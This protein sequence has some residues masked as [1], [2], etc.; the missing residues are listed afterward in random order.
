MQP[1][2]LPIEQVLDE[3]REALEFRM[4]AVLAAPPGAGKTTRVPLALLNA[5][6]ASGKRIL[7]LEP[8]RIAT[9]SAARY[10][11]ASLGEQAGQTVGYRMRHDSR[12]SGATRI[13]VITEGILTRML[14]DDPAL[15][16]VGIVIFDEFHERSL[17]ADLGL[18]LCLQAQSLLRPDLRLLVMSATLDTSRISELMEDAPVVVSVGRAYPV[19][20]RYRSGPRDDAGLIAMATTTIVT[21]L[22]REQG[23]ILVFLP[24]IGEIRRLETKLAWLRLDPAV[25]VATLHGSLSQEAQDRAIASSPAG[26]RKIVLATSIAETSIT[27]EGVRTVIDCGLSRVP[28]FSPRTGLTHLETVPVA[29]DS[30]EQRRGRAGRV[31]PGVCYRL[32]SEAEERQLPLRGVPEICVADLSSLALELAAWGAADPAELR[33]LDSPPAPAYRQAR[34]LLAQLGALD[35]AGATTPHGRR[36]ASLGL[37]PRLAHMLLMAASLGHGQLACELAALLGERDP[38]RAAG[39]AAAFA[40][41]DVRLRVEALRRAALAG[42]S[43]GGS[44]AAAAEAQAW[45][46]IAEEAARLARATGATG[47]AA[48]DIEN[49]GLLL[50]FAYPDRIA[51]RRPDGRY[52]LRNGRGAA[53]RHVQLLAQSDFIVAVELDDQG[54]DCRIDLA[55]SLDY[56]DLERHFGDQIEVEETVDWDR[57]SQSVKA[58]K[59]HRLGALILK[60]IPNPNPDPV[61]CMSTLLRGIEIEGLHILPWTKSAKQIQERLLFLHRLNT[62]WTDF[63]EEA[64]TATLEDWLGSHVYNMRSRA[65]LQRLNLTGIIQDTLSWNDRQELDQQA[66]THFVVPS[67]SRIPIDYSDT[68]A[69]S[70]AVRLQEMFGLADTPRLGWGRV[71]LTLH[72]LSPASRPVQVTRDLASFWRDAYFEVKKDL[73]GRYPKHYWPDDPYSA[74]PT[75]RVRP[76][77]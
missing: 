23:D 8:R 37:Q 26:T 62:Q 70:V 75:N 31:A 48:G 50:A 36:M 63:S 16:D 7:M 9:R 28:M 59:R 29:M 55:A 43:S 33:W 25:S 2:P 66:P 72:L 51:Q 40:A 10:M 18:A 64:L 73:K 13:E 74:V 52:L 17:H 46:R 35:A 56:S 34:E 53:F 47:A 32:W 76:R 1:I 77:P 14:Q 15:E 24:G 45:R 5:P 58:R 69:P 20:T 44:S 6:W 12:V 57:E 3:L 21:A 4:N 61:A 54:V 22:E 39:G 41:A 27:V 38:L 30:A 71:P 68:Q 42:A 49:C 19:E 11:A 60:D 65:D 67:G